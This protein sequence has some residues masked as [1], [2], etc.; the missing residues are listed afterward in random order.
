MTELR[1]EV[2]SEITK[3]SDVELVSVFALF[4]ADSGKML[5]DI[6]GKS[7]S[8]CERVIET[9]KKITPCDAIPASTIDKAVELVRARY[10]SEEDNHE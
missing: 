4:A 6:G 9:I 3:L 10:R 7:S 8:F 2:I 1:A 5:L